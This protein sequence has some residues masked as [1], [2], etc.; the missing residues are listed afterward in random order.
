[1]RGRK[2]ALIIL[3]TEAEYQQLQGWL[4]STTTPVGLV[5]RATVVL[6]VHNGQTI[7]EAARTAGLS[8]THSRKWLQRFVQHRLAGL[9]DAAR[10]GRPPLFSPAGGGARGQNRV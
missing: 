7:K 5:R 6:A 3:L 9:K 8:E 2:S 4:R 10:P 1:M